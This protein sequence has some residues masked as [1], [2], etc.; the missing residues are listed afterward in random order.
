MIV[1]NIKKFILDNK[2]FLMLLTCLILTFCIMICTK[3]NINSVDTHKSKN[4]LIEE[5]INKDF[6]NY[7]NQLNSINLSLRK[8]ING[9]TINSKSASIILNDTILSLNE[10][11]SKVS[12]TVIAN[13]TNPQFIPKFILCLEN[14]ATLYNYCIDVLSYTSNLSVAEITSE[15]LVLKESCIKSYDEL[16]SLGISLSFP[17]ESITFFE[18]LVSYLNTMEKLNK[19]D[20]IKTTQYNNYIKLLTSISSNFSV[21]LEDLKP[22]IDRARIE[23]RS[24]DMILDDIKLKEEKL[25]VLKKDFSYSA[26]PEGCISYYNCLNNI[27]KL[28]STYLNTLKIAIIYEKSS[29][30][31]ESNKSNID[32]NYEN[33]YSKFEDVK[34]SFNSLI[35][36]LE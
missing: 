12:A 18:N 19:E 34:T 33:A 35:N 24:F 8:C 36:S 7:V 31:Y 16:S 3:S 23:N 10:L 5:S 17:D 1:E 30:G 22:A 13:N 20:E 6:E 32:K 25:S 28:Y 11:K 9:V 21:L 27:F 4:V 2:I 15:I 14:T 26:I 29:D